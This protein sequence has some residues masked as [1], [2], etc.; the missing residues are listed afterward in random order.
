M[1][2]KFGPKKGK[3]PILQRLR[4]HHD[5]AAKFLHG[6]RRYAQDRLETMLYMPVLEG[7]LH[8]QEV[9]SM[10]ILTVR[11]TVDTAKRVLVYWQYRRI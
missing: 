10:S 2:I 3:T 8:N 4:R 7:E 5:K 11:V 6:N 9:P 1:Q